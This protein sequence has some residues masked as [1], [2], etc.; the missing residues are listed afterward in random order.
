MEILPS[1]KYG[2]HRLFPYKGAMHPGLARRMISLVHPLK[3]EI[4]LDPF[5]G[6]G[7]IPVECMMHGVD[8][9][10]LDALPTAVIATRTKLGIAPGEEPEIGAHPVRL[11]MLTAS[12][13]TQKMAYDQ[14]I[15]AI[16]EMRKLV[17][18]HELP[19][20]EVK[21]LGGD[22]LTNSLPRCAHIVTSPP[23]GDLI[24]YVDE[25]AGGLLT[26][27]F[28]QNDITRYAQAV[29]FFSDPHVYADNVSASCQA[30]KR[31]IKPNGKVCLTVGP[32]KTQDCP[33][34]WRDRMLKAGFS[35]TELFHRPYNS[36][37]NEIPG[38]EIQ[39]YANTDGDDQVQSKA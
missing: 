36:T 26:C 23:Y 19:L 17:A 7:T 35:L 4:V 30:F 39:L 15:G 38:E 12:C 34:I 10:G 27:G 3:D 1:S 16:D 29:R 5:C 20:G 25:A 22:I 21:V 11:H 14:I 13:P 32:S 24:D 2:T 8:A 37:T 31:A 33:A 6:S 9:L 18:R 28:T